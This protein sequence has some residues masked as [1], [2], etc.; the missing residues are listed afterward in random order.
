MQ[1]VVKGGLND[2]GSNIKS[3]QS[4]KVLMNGGT[5]T[6][7][8]SAV[9]LTK[10]IVR[11]T[12]AP[13]SQSNPS[14]N[15]VTVSGELTNA[16]T[17]TFTLNQTINNITVLWEVIEFNNVKS[18]QSGNW[19]NSLA[20]STLTVSSVNPSKSMLFYSDW[21]SVVAD[22]YSMFMNIEITSATLLTCT[23]IDATTFN[24]KWF[25]VEFN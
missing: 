2:G 4:G 11:I 21:T 23:R 22:F 7:T 12:Y 3:K 8:I 20:S 25:L 15:A 14:A 24:I 5:K 9:D 13:S 6:V 17:I 10:A 19:N 18:L 1:G 16:T